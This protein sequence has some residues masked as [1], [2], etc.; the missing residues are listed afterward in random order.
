MK[1][2]NEA[3][4]FHTGPHGTSFQCN[5]SDLRQEIQ[6]HTPRGVTELQVRH[7]FAEFG[8]WHAL[9]VHPHLNGF[10]G[11][12]TLHFLPVTEP[13]EESPALR[14]PSP[15]DLPRIRFLENLLEDRFSHQGHYGTLFESD[16]C[17]LRDGVLFQVRFRAARSQVRRDFVEFGAWHALFFH[18]HPQIHRFPGYDAITFTEVLAPRQS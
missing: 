16:H 2:L 4:L 1:F 13:L 10:P 9:Q 15:Q 6:F 3:P 8:A 14:D 12:D 11:Y 18:F 5:R 17:D 7:D